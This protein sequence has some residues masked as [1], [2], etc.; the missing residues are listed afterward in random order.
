ME[1]EKIIKLRIMFRVNWELQWKLKVVSDIFFLKHF[2]QIQILN[3]YQV[4]AANSEK[5]LAGGHISSTLCV[6]VI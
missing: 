3:S 4:R 1:L 6:H 5:N 2:M